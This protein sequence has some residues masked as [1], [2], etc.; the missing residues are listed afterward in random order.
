MPPRPQEVLAM[1]KGNLQGI[2]KETEEDKMY[3]LWLQG[4]LTNLYFQSYLR[5]RDHL[6][7]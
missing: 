5:E 7:F 2:V 3:S 4:L 1:Y 6:G